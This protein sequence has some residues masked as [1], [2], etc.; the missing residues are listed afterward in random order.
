MCLGL[1]TQRPPARPPAP[2]GPGCRYQR[3]A[4]LLRPGAP[5]SELMSE[6]DRRWLPWV[7]RFRE[8]ARYTRRWGAEGREGGKG[9]PLLLLLL[10][11]FLLL[12][13]LLRLVPGALTR[14]ACPLLRGRLGGGPAAAAA[15]CACCGPRCRAVGRR[16]RPLT[17]SAGRLA[18]ALAGGCQTCLAR[19]PLLARAGSCL[20][21]W[22][23]RR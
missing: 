4:V 3:C 19:R 10:L 8:L 9:G 18:G 7:K 11:L 23:G 6:A 21:G 15:C 16:A 12:A 13:L 5:Y 17:G 22:K 20:G 1:P 14:A 2:H